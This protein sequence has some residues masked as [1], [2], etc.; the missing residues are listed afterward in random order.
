MSD[1][2]ATDT[3]LCGADKSPT[4]YARSWT[5][6]AAYYCALRRLDQNWSKLCL[7]RAQP[8]N[9]TP[10]LALGLFWGRAD[11]YTTKP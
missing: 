2:V 10:D 3:A 11:R 1:V 4:G 8:Q 5:H 9:L 7:D 6:C